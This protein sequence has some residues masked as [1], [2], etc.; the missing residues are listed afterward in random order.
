LDPEVWGPT[1]VS[2]RADTSVRPYF[3]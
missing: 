1:Y 2:A 3:R